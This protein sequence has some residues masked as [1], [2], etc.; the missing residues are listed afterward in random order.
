MTYLKTL[1]TL[2]VKQ[3]A[4]AITNLVTKFLEDLGFE[5]LDSDYGR[6]HIFENSKGDQITYYAG[7]FGANSEPQILGN[8]YNGD[9][10]DPSSEEAVNQVETY[11]EEIKKSILK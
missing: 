2:T 3:Q 7:Y 6:D 10:I 11:L 8:W 4:S 1:P 5:Y 9:D